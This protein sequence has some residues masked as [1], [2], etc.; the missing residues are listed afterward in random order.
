M[1]TAIHIQ[2]IDWAIAQGYYLSV[3][4]YSEDEFDLEDSQDRD[5]I[6]EACEATELPNV[7]IEKR[8]MYAKRRIAIFSVVDE[9]IPHETI[10]DFIA[11]PGGEFDTWW[12]EKVDEV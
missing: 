3:R 8:G 1:T 4:D 2:A 10:N 12:N 7:H 11:K 5:A 9:G 6:I